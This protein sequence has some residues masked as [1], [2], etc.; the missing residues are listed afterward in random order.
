MTHDFIL[1]NVDHKGRVF[2]RD[3]RVLRDPSTG[4][5]WYVFAK[6]AQ[7]DVIKL[8]ARPDVSPRKHP[9]Y[10][11]RVMRG[12]LTKREAENVASIVSNLIRD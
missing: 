9:H 12:W 1:E 3:V 7:S 6:D 10:N 4:P 11:L 8:I 2:N 5:G